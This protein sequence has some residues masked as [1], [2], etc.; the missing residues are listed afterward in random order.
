M[1]TGIPRVDAMNVTWLA[2]LTG[3]TLVF[4]LVAITVIL[5]NFFGSRKAW[6]NDMDSNGKD[7]PAE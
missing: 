7:V 1:F 3:G 5:K 2:I 4:S 6:R